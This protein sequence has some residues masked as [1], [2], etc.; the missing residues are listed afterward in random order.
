M[1]IYIENQAKDLDQTKKTLDKFESAKII[2]IDNY[3]NL[4]DK[5]LPS[6]A[7][8]NSFIIAKLNS[9]AI[10]DAPNWYWH[11]DKTSYFF[12]TSLNCVFDCSYCFL[13]WAFKNDIPVY[14]VNYDDIRK[15]IE[16]KVKNINLEQEK[17]ENKKNDYELNLKTD[18]KYKDKIWFYS[19]DY[20]DILGMDNISGFLKNFVPFFEKINSP[21]HSVRTWENF[22]SSMME[23]RTKS[24]NIKSILD[25]WFIPKNTEFAFSL[26]PQDLIDKYEFWTSSLDDRIKSINILLEK[27]YNVWLRFLPLLPVKNYKEIYWQFIEEIKSK[28][29]MDKVSSTFVSWLLYTK[30]DYNNILKKY[31]KLDILY[32]L[33]EEDWVFIREKREMRDYFYELFRSLDKKCFICLDKK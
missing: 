19:S 2:Y 4:F 5:E 20:S 13:K 31:P 9:S 33:K 24:A 23:I 22:T 21:F 30:S 8:N 11:N 26:N 28:I 1:L 3:K 29:D 27:G 18:V 14:F 12:K 25:L 6:W 10:T 17:I 32:R 16:E 15:Q 7:N